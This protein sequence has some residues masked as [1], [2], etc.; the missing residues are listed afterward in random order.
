MKTIEAAK[1]KTNACLPQII[2]ALQRGKTDFATENW[3]CCCVERRVSKGMQ[4]IG[5]KEACF[6]SGANVLLMQ[7]GGRSSRL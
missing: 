2:D 1:N 5:R 4:M 6:P 7:V 3:W